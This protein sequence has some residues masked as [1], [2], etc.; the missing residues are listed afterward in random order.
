MDSAPI[1]LPLA[2]REEQV[3]GLEAGSLDIIGDQE[4]GAGYDPAVDL[5][6]IRIVRAAHV[7]MLARLEPLP[8]KNGLRRR[9]DGGED[10]SAVDG[11]PEAAG[12]LDRDR[13]R[14]HRAEL[15]G[16]RDP[17]RG[18]RRDVPD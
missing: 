2:L 11:L 16:E 15:R 14:Q 1:Q 12:R 3:T 10:P 9:G 17:G 4:V 5:P 18:G 7:Q 8:G 6:P 13:A